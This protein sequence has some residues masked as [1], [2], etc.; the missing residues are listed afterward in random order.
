MTKTTPNLVFWVRT[1]NY[2]IRLVL[3]LLLAHGSG[4][5]FGQERQRPRPQPTDAGLIVYRAA[6]RH[7]TNNDYRIEV[8]KEGGEWQ[9]L[10]GYYA[11]NMNKGPFPGPTLNAQT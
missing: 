1:Q 3:F 5:V 6:H 2:C 10:A 9:Q 7:Y 11:I 4:I 8:R